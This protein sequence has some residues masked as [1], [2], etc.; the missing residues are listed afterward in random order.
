[1]MIMAPFYTTRAL[2][3]RHMDPF[4]AHGLICS[5]LCCGRSCRLI[6]F[7]LYASCPM[8]CLSVWRFIVSF[9]H[10]NRSSYV[11]QILKVNFILPCVFIYIFFFYQTQAKI[12]DSKTIPWHTQGGGWGVCSFCVCVLLFYFYKLK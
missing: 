2:R 4:E 9:D 10:S 6:S 1:M 3:A 7:W 12:V 5:P 8:L 11:E